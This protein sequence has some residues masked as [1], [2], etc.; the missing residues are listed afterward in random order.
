MEKPTIQAMHRLCRDTMD[1]ISHRIVPGMSLAQV[2]TECETYLIENGSD[3]FWYW[4]AGA[5]VFRGED[6]HLSVSGKHYQTS[7]SRL[8]ENDIITIDLCPQ[9]QKI[10]GIMPERLYWKKVLL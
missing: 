4:D 9:K 1:Y 10:W 5:F 7:D 3:S 8:Q 2:R 6:T